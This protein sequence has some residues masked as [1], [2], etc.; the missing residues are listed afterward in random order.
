MEDIRRLGYHHVT[1]NFTHL[2]ECA[3]F[4]TSSCLCVASAPAGV[5]RERALFLTAGSGVETWWNIKIMCILS[6]WAQD[7]VGR[8]PDGALGNHACVLHER[9][10]GTNLV[11]LTW[12]LMGQRPCHG[13]HCSALRIRGSGAFA[14]L[15]T[16]APFIGCVTLNSYANFV[17]AV[18]FL[19]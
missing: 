18:S 19:G 1:L 4:I 7:A 8:G 11:L 10:E 2:C 6:H 12:Q 3:P 17:L 13:S 14:C 15:L 5:F 16:S 9:S